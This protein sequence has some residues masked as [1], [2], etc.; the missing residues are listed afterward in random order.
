MAGPEASG[1][2]PREFEAE[3]FLA[4]LAR[5]SAADRAARAVSERARTRSLV[6]QAAGAATWTGLLVDLAEV[7]ARVACSL[8]GGGKVTGRLVGVG[9]DFAV[10]ERPGAGPVLIRL[11][12]VTAV[13]P[14]SPVLPAPGGD[15]RPALDLTF[16]AALDLLAGE[17][18]PVV[19]R[20]ATEAFTGRVTA[21]GTD[22]LT[23]VLEGGARRVVHLP[24]RAVAAVELR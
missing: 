15:R 13:A 5:W 1:F 23:M 21:C 11:D 22:V 16:A 2:E 24:L 12:G 9:R 7:E 6:E 10:V 19:V 8:V 4:R 20:T 18:A 3:D 17:G 14:A